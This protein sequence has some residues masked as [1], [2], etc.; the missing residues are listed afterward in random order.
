MAAGKIFDGKSFAALPQGQDLHGRQWRPYIGYSGGSGG[1]LCEFRDKR[2][3]DEQELSREVAGGKSI[4]DDGAGENRSQSD[5]KSSRCGQ[6]ESASCQSRRG[7]AEG[8][9]SASQG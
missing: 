2:G 9:Y 6:A 3:A 7:Q 8:G 4:K 5:S 1:R